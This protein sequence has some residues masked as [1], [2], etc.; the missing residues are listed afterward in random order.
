MTVN[1]DRWPENVPRNYNELARGEWGKYITKTVARLNKVGRNAEDLQQYIWEKILSTD[2]LEKYVTRMYR[3][4]PP[5]EAET[6]FYLTAKEACTYLGITWGQWNAKLWYYHG[7]VLRPGNTWMPLPV[8]G[9]QFSRQAKYNFRDIVRVA[10]N[11]TFKKHG[12][13]G[14]LPEGMVIPEDHLE[15]TPM[16]SIDA[17]FMG[18]LKN[19]IHNHYC[20]FVRTKER[21]EKERPYD[22]FSTF[23]Q[24][25]QKMAEPPNY[26]DML[27]ADNGCENKAEVY[28]EL[29]I[30]IE[31]IRAHAGDQAKD[32]LNFLDDG[33]TM[34]EAIRKLKVT[35]KEKRTLERLL[36]T[37]T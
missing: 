2:L 24:R 15:T 33:Y 32:I 30:R 11:A 5:V 36:L 29:H 4:A 9:G 35:T 10:S 25:T 1:L 18:Y 34:P 26:E 16:K 21:R 22:T 12:E 13:I 20:N 23:T 27:P 19:A 37:G 3:D 28:A 8:T 14:T 7:K 6:E 17:N 31:R